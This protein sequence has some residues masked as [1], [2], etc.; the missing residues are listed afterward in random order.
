MEKQEKES[1]LVYQNSDGS[2]TKVEMK[3][4]VV[5]GWELTAPKKTDIESLLENGK[6]RKELMPEGADGVFLHCRRNTET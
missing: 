5:I 1:T 3:G 4:G 2:T 6:I